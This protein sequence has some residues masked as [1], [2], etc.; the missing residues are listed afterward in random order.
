LL[1]RRILRGKEQ[2]DRTN[3]RLGYT[4]RPRPDGTLI[5]V[6]GASVGECV[7]ALPLIDALLKA[8]PC[9]VLVTSGTVTSAKVM[10]DRLPAGA[11]HQFVPIDTPSATVR[12]LEHWKPQAGLFVDSDIWPN[13]IL[14]AREHGVKLALIN[15][16]MTERSFASWQRVRKTAAEILAS[17]QACLAQDEEIGAR[18]RALGTP[19]VTVIGSLKADAPALPADPEKLEALRQAIGARPVLLAAQTH[20]GEEETVLPAHDA[21]RRSFPEL[22]TIIVPRHPDRAGD[23][24]MLCGT[25][26]NKR[27]STGDLP[28]SGTAIYIADT[29]GELGLFYRLVHFCFVGG[30]LIRH[31]G[32]NPLEPAKL[33]CA[34]LTGPHTFNFTTAYATLLAAQGIG[35]V[36]T[37][38]E[39]CAVAAKLLGDPAEAIRL[40]QAALTGAARLGGAVTKTVEIVVKMLDART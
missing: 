4:D 29:M 16:R 35:R 27:R 40:G 26:A 39:I 38:G 5:W 23:I 21:L 20:A 37:A 9:S 22:L 19:N 34:V 36:N 25:R 11:F 33:G 7:A 10:Q 6:H 12:F 24:A 15:A 13:L 28:D 17:F 30:S 8:V 2:Q 1:R 3:E 14:G 18:F 32:Q 31:G